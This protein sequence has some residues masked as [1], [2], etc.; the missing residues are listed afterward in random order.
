MKKSSIDELL[1]KY[2]NNHFIQSFQYLRK[3]D[4]KGIQLQH[5]LKADYELNKKS[6][7]DLTSA[8]PV[9]RIVLQRQTDLIENMSMEQIESHYSNNRKDS[10]SHQRIQNIEA[11]TPSTICHC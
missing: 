11:I 3:E 4:I 10:M 6:R 5:R 2:N 9:D 7:K 1:T 8:M